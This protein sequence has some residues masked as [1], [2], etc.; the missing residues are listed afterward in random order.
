MCSHDA[1]LLPALRRCGEGGDGAQS[2]SAGEDREGSL[3]GELPRGT[4]SA[5]FKITLHCV[6]VLTF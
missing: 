5:P 4:T 3:R 1:P 6:F 2:E